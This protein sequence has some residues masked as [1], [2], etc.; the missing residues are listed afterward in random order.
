MQGRHAHTHRCGPVCMEGRVLDDQSSR[1]ALHTKHEII[2]PLVRGKTHVECKGLRILLHANW[3]GNAGQV[4][5]KHVPMSRRVRLRLS[6]LCWPAHT[7]CEGTHGMSVKLTPNR[8]CEQRLSHMLEQCVACR[9]HPCMAYQ[10]GTVCD[11]KVGCVDECHRTS[12]LHRRHTAPTHA[13]C[14]SPHLSMQAIHAQG[15][16]QAMC[17]L[18]LLLRFSLTLAA[19]LLEKEERMSDT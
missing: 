1:R 8:H 4:C 14:E 11:D 5:H 6:R 15:L 3:R 18:L 13:H 19:W 12:V 2:T 17:L 7:R 10:E 16:C 9:L